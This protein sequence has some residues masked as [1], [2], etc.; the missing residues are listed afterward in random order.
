MPKED[1]GPFVR[2]A[3]DQGNDAARGH[4]TQ[5]AAMVMEA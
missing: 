2:H 3:V 5:A 4:R 1:R